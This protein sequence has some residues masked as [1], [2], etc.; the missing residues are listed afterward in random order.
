M[1]YLKNI[2]CPHCGRELET[3]FYKA[4][5]YCKEKGIYTNYETIYDLK[6]TKL[7]KNNNEKGIY[8]YSSFF[9][10]KE[11]SSKISINEGNTP[12]IKLERLGK[13]WGL[14]NLYLKDESKNPTMS[15][16]DRMCS[17]MISKA[18]EMKAPGV[19]IA[20]TGNQGAAVAAYCAVAK[21]PCVIFTTP[22]VSPTMKIFMQSFGAYVFVT[23]TMED[24]VTMM[25]KLVEEYNYFPASGLE[26][27]PIGSCC[28]AI[29][30]YKTIAF[31]VFE[32]LNNN[33][34]DYFIVPISYGDTLYGIYKGMS[35]LKEMGYVDKTP[36]FVAAEVFG[37]AKTTLAAD[38]SV[39]LAVETSSSIQ[40]SIAAGNIAYL[41]LKALK[42]SN[43]SAE[44][45]CDEEALEMQKL[46]CE[47]EGILAETSSVA[48]LVAL[49][50]MLENKKI[51]SSDKIVLLLTSTGVKTPEIIEQW[52]PKLPSINPN[53]ESFK[54]EMLNTYK[55][56]F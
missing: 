31:E 23:P 4:C 22:N 11:N 34:P 33:I 32:Q 26:N 50:K 44:T 39:P 24:R 14:D 19:V 30:A 40:T 12:L 10:L 5:P 1:S 38:S 13:L 54:E 17:L 18:I 51:S 29:D 45:S 15:H 8:K 6:N 16:K 56:K 42:E 21:I 28:F 3:E 9:P 48:S 52:L 55:F 27:P 47:T 37:A 41:T 25:K 53:M 46:L 43:G 35:D 36:K 49:K 7:D 2:V 20:S